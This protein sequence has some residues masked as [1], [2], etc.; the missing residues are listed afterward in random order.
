MYK[1]SKWT[2]SY[3]KSDRPNWQPS[4]LIISYYDD[5]M[6]PTGSEKRE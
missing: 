5:R 6:G 1:Y 3:F 2:G 4:R